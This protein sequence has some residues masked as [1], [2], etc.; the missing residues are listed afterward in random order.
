M[1]YLHGVLRLEEVLNEDGSTL[2]K[3]GR[4]VWRLVDSLEWRLMSPFQAPDDKNVLVVP[5][6]FETDLASVPKL[7]R[8][9]IPASGPWQRAAIIHDYCYVTKGECIPAWW[10]SEMDKREVSD[11]IFKHAMKAAGVSS[12]VRQLLWSAV[13][14]GG[15]AGW[16]T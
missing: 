16:G 11:M 14:V 2:M 12:P 5:A 3:Q 4:A 9:L 10:Y 8:G 1:G 13:R 6:G 15:A 7:V